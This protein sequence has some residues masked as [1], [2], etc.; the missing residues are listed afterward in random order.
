MLGATLTLAG[1]AMVMSFPKIVGN[2]ILL[3]K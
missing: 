1:G 2:S 3:G